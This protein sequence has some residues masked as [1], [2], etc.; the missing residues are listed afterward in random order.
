MLTNVFSKYIVEA[1]INKILNSGGFKILFIGKI[2]GNNLGTPWD[3]C[4]GYMLLFKWTEALNDELMVGILPLF[5]RHDE[6]ILS[7][8][9]IYNLKLV[10]L[11]EHQTQLQDIS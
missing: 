2:G 10:T 5:V 9:G 3:I 11:N 1:A 7:A 8:M 4:V 6:M